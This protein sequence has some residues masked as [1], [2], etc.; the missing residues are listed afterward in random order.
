MFR[1]GKFSLIILTRCNLKCRLCCEYVPQNEPFPD[2]TPD[3]ER[4]ILYAFFSAV[5]HVDTLHLTG[6]GSPFSIR[7]CQR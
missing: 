6:G 5:D 2:M 3:E 7:I 4:K 1:L